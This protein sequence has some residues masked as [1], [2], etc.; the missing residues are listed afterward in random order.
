VGR[1]ARL[2]EAVRPGPGAVPLG[3]D[4]FYLDAVHTTAHYGLTTISQCNKG[5]V[6]CR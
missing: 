4:R 6:K 2:A 3:D 5:P 1:P